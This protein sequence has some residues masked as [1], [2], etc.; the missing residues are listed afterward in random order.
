[1]HWLDPTGSRDELGLRTQGHERGYCESVADK[2][3]KKCGHNVVFCLLK[4]SEKHY[5][6]T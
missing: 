6:G 4:Y 3:W 2:A 1:M 5:N